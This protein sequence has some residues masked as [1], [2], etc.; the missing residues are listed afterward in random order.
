MRKTELEKVLSKNFWGI[1]RAKVVSSQDPLYGGR[2]RV[3][4]FGI[5]SQ[6]IQEVPD[7]TLPWA[8]PATSSM[9]DTAQG[10][11][12]AIPRVGSIVWI[13]FDG[14]NHNFP[15]YFSSAP[16]KDNWNEDADEDNIVMSLEDRNLKIVNTAGVEITVDV[17]GL[18]SINATNIEVIAEE[19]ISIVADG[20]ITMEAGGNITETAGGTHESNGSRIEHN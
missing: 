3:R 17:D 4:I 14:G 5:H 19:D 1:Y 16:D 10:G 7:E 15:I 8:F 20:D 2:I 12:F 13:F 18:V 9:G 11:F 6:D